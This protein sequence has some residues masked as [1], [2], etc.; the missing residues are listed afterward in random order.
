MPSQE[1]HE[2]FPALFL[3]QHNVEGPV[4]RIGE[5][6]QPHPGT[7]NPDVQH[8]HHHRPQ[9]HG[10]LACVNLAVEG[11]LNLGSLAQRV[12]IRASSVSRLEETAPPRPAP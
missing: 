2:L 8:F 10:A 1:C 3:N 7:E 11:P 9:A 6:R 4:G 12:Q 5:R